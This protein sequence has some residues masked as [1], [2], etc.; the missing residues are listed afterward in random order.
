[1]TYN[2]FDRFQ[3]IWLGSILGFTILGRDS[4]RITQSTED[5]QWLKQRRQATVV[6]WKNEGVKVDERS[7]LS[8]KYELN[9][10][11]FLP[12]IIFY[13]DD[14]EHLR[15][16]IANAYLSSMDS[17]PR[18]DNREDFLIW[19]CLL[20][21]LFHHESNAPIDCELLRATAVS[22]A[23]AEQTS[24]A[25]KLAMTV[26]AVKE[27]ISWH[28]LKAI[29]ASDRDREQTAIALAFYCFATTPA[30]FYLSIRRSA[31]LGSHL[32]WLTVL[33]TGTLSAA[34]NGM[35]GIPYQL[36]IIAHDNSTV[37]LESKLAE[38]LFQVWSG[39]Y[40][41][42]E[43]LKTYPSKLQA[44]AVPQL[45]QPRRVLKIVSQKKYN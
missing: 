32:S 35:A 45:I 19:S 21:L 11:S 3:G 36:R 39:V 1:M 24:L 42:R 10:L 12:L 44:I 6:L 31:R 17:R 43:P 40:S 34:Y 14:P 15:Q 8:A 13:G 22:N 26:A 23:K 5:T 30:E 20:T 18:A 27:G 41:A 25:A 28:Q 38:R 29:I 33:L 16:I 9:L 7:Q 4:S 2:T 37:R